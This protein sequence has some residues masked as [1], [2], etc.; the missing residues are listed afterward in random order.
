MEREIV[1]LVHRPDPGTDGLF[2][3]HDAD[4]QNEISKPHV[5]QEETIS[6]LRG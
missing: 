5:R 4:L 6:A 1:K 3:L 2:S